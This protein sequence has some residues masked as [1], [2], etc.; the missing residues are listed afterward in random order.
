[1]YERIVN[2]DKF[3]RENKHGYGERIP[4]HDVLSEDMRSV[5]FTGSFEECVQFLKSKCSTG[6][7]ED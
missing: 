1:M 6:A 2:T 3:R 5:D 7:C 4:L